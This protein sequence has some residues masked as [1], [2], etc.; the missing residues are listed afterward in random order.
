MYMLLGAGP[1]IQREGEELRAG[2]GRLQPL[3]KKKKR[4]SAPRRWAPSSCGGTCKVL[5]WT[6]AAEKREEAKAPAQRGELAVPG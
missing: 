6:R 5:P 3:K 1:S 4:N 2:K